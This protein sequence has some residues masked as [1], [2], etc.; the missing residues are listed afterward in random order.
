MIEDHTHC[1]IC[2][3]L[4]AQ[5]PGYDWHIVKVDGRTVKYC[6]G[7]CQEIYEHPLWERGG[8]KMKTLFYL[9]IM[10][11]LLA[12]VISKAET[13]VS[14]PDITITNTMTDEGSG[15]GDVKYS[16]D[17]ETWTDTEP[18]ATGKE[19]IL[20]GGD[21]EHCIFAMFSDQAGNWTEPLKACAILDST[22]PAGEIKIMGLKITVSFIPVEKD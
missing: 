18:Y 15:M 17:N 10:L 20:V 9:I 13:Y 3:K 8:G 16:L 14:S 1:Y 22:V 7:E 6:D 2:G 4:L 21:G 12:P 11:L 19:M 5:W